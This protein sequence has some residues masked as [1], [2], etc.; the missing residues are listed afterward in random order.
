M[1]GDKAVDRSSVGTRSQSKKRKI[2]EKITSSP[3]P[4]PLIRRF[5]RKRTSKCKK[6]QGSRTQRNDMT[7]QP[8]VHVTPGSEIS[9]GKSNKQQLQE[10]IG[11]QKEMMK[12]IT[13]LTKDVSTIKGEMEKRKADEPVEIPSKTIIINDPIWL[14]IQL[15]PLC[16]M[17]ID[18]PEF[19]R[20]RSIKQMGGCFSVYPGACHTRFEHSIGT[21]HL[22][23]VFGRELKRNT[24]VT[25]IKITD[26]EILCLEVAGLCHDLGHGPFSHLFD[27]NFIKKARPEKKWEHETASLDMIDKIFKRIEQNYIED[28]HIDFIKNLIKEQGKPSKYTKRKRKVKPYLFE[29][30]ANKLNSIDVDKWD[31]FSRDCH[32]LGLHH[33][34]QCERSIKV[35]RV[36]KHDDWHISFPKSDYHHMFD[37]FS[38][39][40]TIHRRA[41]LHPVVK[42]VEMMITDALLI[43]DKYLLFPPNKKKNQK[44]LSD[45]ID[46]MD[47][48]LW[49]TDNVLNQIK[50]L[51]SKTF[52]RIQKAQEIKRA[53]EIKKAQE[54]VDR[55]ERR[56]LYKMICEKRVIWGERSRSSNDQE[57]LQQL[58]KDKLEVDGITQDS[59]FEIKVEVFS[60]GNGNENPMTNVKLYQKIKTKKDEDNGAPGES[61]DEE[62]GVMDKNETVVRAFMKETEISC[63]L[64]VHFEQMYIRLYWKDNMEDLKQTDIIEKFSNIDELPY[65]DGDKI[66]LE[67]CEMPAIT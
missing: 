30:I 29:I 5:P 67:T 41:C 55:I 47:A 60:Y 9:S 44:C 51:D 2:D 22:A 18:T 36:V 4:I 28:K 10:I 53:Q 34:F 37:M 3:G 7:Q 50:A 17:I 13:S 59:S 31:Y 66:M 15:H 58:M 21:C 26:K 40:F 14:T 11:N 64:P 19:Q 35:A 54:I 43:A 32:M 1:M 52:P 12:V 27:Q 24:T 46:N 56:V 49:V 25:E 45:S 65:K 63:M 23:G 39:R 48:Y 33:N 20:L 57:N 42:A 6:S 38:T 62:S 8:N 61:E 16:V